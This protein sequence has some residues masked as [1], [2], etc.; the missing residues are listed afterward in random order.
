MVIGKISSLATTIIIFVL[1][2]LFLKQAYSTSI[3]KA[4]TDVGLGLSSTAAG[5]SSLINSFLSPITGLLG[6]VQGFFGAL[7]NGGR[8]EPSTAGRDERRTPDA[9]VQNT[10]IIKVTNGKTSGGTSYNG[11]VSNVPRG[12]TISGASS[13]SSWSFL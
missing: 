4:G 7:G 9:S 5:I 3:G 13:G 10:D 12:V 6:T 11:S 1:A 8:P 2:F